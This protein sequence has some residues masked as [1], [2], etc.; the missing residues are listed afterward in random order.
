MS[1]SFATMANG[2]T[3]VLTVPQIQREIGVIYAELQMSMP[4]HI[5]YVTAM[6]GVG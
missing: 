6:E 1:F 3:T 5:F 2:M 4:V